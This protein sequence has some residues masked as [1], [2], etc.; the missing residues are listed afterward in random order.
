MRLRLVFRVLLGVFGL[1]ADGDSES[2]TDQFGEVGFVGVRGHAAHF[3]GFAE[4]VSA[5]GQCD[6]ECGGGF[7]GIVEEE[8]VEIAHAVEEQAIGML[9]FDAPKLRHHGRWR[10][11]GRGGGGGFFGGR[12]MSGGM[13]GK[14]SVRRRRSFVFEREF[15]GGR[16]VL[17]GRC[18]HGRCFWH[19]SL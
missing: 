7:F 3:Y 16:W 2:F 6:I 19:A 12:R 5:M 9:F 11:G 1:L 18:G 15:E 17:W 14:M 4:M 13:S 8:F 10:G